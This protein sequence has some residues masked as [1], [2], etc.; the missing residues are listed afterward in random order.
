MLE[1]PSDQGESN[2][3]KGN[4]KDKTKREIELGSHMRKYE[5]NVKMD[6][7]RTG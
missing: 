5:Q 1:G 7:K 3:K 4:S 6:L 2:T